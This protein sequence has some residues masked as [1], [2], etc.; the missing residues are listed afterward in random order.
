MLCHDNLKNYYI[1]NFSLNQDFNMSLTEIENMIPFEREI[2]V[3]QILNKIE[4]AK[5]KESGGN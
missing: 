4:E 5:K 3:Y 2:W 1:V